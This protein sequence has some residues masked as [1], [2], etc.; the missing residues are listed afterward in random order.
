MK[1]SKRNSQ[2]NVNLNYVHEFQHFTANFDLVLSCNELLPEPSVK[3]TITL[4][5][6]TYYTLIL[7]PLINYYLYLVIHNSFVYIYHLFACLLYC[8]NV[9]DIVSVSILLGI[10]KYAIS[11]P[12]FPIIQ[13]KRSNSRLRWV[14]WAPTWRQPTS[15]HSDR[16]LRRR[17]QSIAP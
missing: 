7:N 13:W 17:G 8:C 10:Y 3:I 12:L 14:R 5:D 1:F 9:F 16:V 4:F 11:C 2:L 6:I 15:I